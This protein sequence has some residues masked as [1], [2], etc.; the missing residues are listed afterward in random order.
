MVPKATPPTHV[1]KKKRLRKGR[2]LP[3]DVRRAM[4]R[5]IAPANAPSSGPATS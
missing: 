5:Y 3:P 1:P 2:P 4:V